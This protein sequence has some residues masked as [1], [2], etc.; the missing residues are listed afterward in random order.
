MGLLI[1]GE[2]VDEKPAN[3]DG[4][5]ERAE[6]TFRS[7]VTAD[8]TPGPTGDAGF[9]AE[10]G[11]YH[12]YVSLACPW[13][14]RTL[15]M[16]HLKGLEKTV[17][18]SVAHWFMGNDGWTFEDGA[19]VIP[20]PI[21]DAD[22]L[23]DVYLRAKSDFTGRVTVPVLWDRE[24][25]TIVSNE[26]S[27]IIRMFN[28]AFDDAG[29]AEGDYYPERLRDEVDAINAPVFANVNNGVYRAGFATT[30]QAYDKAV[31]KLFNMLDQLEKRLNAHRYHVG[32]T[33][34]EADI[35]LFTTLYRFEP[36]YFGHF[37]CN[38]RRIKDYP[39]L[40]NYL[41]DVFQHNGISETCNL[42]HCKQHYYSSHLNINPTGIVPAGP[43]VDYS[44]P[45][46]RAERFG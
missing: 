18:L 4:E 8:G 9:K 33:F 32:D 30:Q 31:E 25:E 12:L 24:R 23:R 46:D 1:D 39:S 45:H 5:F 41:L 38:V 6:T 44:A 35:R 2:W 16:R 22:Y 15:I 13:A 34:T 28:S 37:K 10:A 43:D 29:A 36:V 27:E 11:R 21:N 40:S 26:S 19:G 7:W 17:S 42:E 3:D 20:D 14:H